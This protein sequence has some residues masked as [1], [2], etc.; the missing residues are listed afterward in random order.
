MSTLVIDDSEDGR[1][2]FSAVL[3]GGGYREVVVL[4]SAAAAFSYLALGTPC[5]AAADVNLIFLDVAMPDIDGFQACT[6]IRCDPR[7]VDSPI[8]MITALDDLQSVEHAFECGATD[9]L[10]KPLKAVDLLACARAKLNLHAEIER[11]NAR[12]CNLMQY[13]PFRFAF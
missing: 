9:Y 6:L 2:I 10:T 3:A 5:A 4:D 13:E 1:E 7:Y 11:R 12:E 8:V